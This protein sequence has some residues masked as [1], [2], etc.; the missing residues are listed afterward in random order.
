MRNNWL[1]A[2]YACLLAVVSIITGEIIT[3]I[4]LGFILISLTNIHKTLKALLVETK[5]KQ[6]DTD[7]R[8]ISNEKA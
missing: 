7:H 1:F 5:R 4:M 2:L 6:A 8:T 3:Y